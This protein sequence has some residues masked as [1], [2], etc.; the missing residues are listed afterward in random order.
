MSNTEREAGENHTQE[1]GDE[2]CQPETLSSTTVAKIAEFASN[3][4]S[5]NVERLR[6]DLVRSLLE[7]VAYCCSGKVCAFFPVMASC[8]EVSVVLTIEERLSVRVK[9]GDAEAKHLFRHEDPKDKVESRFL[10]LL[11]GC[12]FLAAEGPADK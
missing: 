2:G 10:R 5:E 8:V 9:M 7:I 4:T 12:A 6:N 11:D 3:H 1:W